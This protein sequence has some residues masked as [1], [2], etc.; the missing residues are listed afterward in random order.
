[1]STTN[2]RW[3]T[4]FSWRRKERELRRAPPLSLAQTCKPV[5]S[6]YNICKSSS[7]GSNKGCQ[8]LSHCNPFN[9]GG[10]LLKAP[11]PTIAIPLSS[12]V[13]PSSRQPSPIR[14]PMWGACRLPYSRTPCFSSNF[15]PPLCQKV[16][17][18]APTQLYQ[19]QIDELAPEQRLFITRVRVPQFFAKRYFKFLSF[20]FDP[21]TM[22]SS[23][24]SAVPE[25]ACI[26]GSLSAAFF[27][28]VRA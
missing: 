8:F 2:P 6:T 18:I 19:Q 27:N 7:G 17:H 11:A 14:C 4:R 24:D 26:S 13:H 25:S 10:F 15:L 12:R 22:C 5:S 20:R 9:R 28:L 23:P 21:A 3:K 16:T 1:M